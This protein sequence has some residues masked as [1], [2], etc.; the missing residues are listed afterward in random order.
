MDASRTNLYSWSSSSI[1]HISFQSFN[2]L[3]SLFFVQIRVRAN[4][5]SRSKWNRRLIWKQWWISQIWTDLS[6]KAVSGTEMKADWWATHLRS[7]SL[8]A[9]RHIIGIDSSGGVTNDYWSHKRQH[10]NSNSNN[11]TAGLDCHEP[12]EI[13]CLLP[14][15]LKLEVACSQ[16]NLLFAP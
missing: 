14:T 9:G 11:N 7:C 6:W 8:P 2:T 13:Q 5:C 16:Y 1:Q 4:E 12:S 15:Y 3:F 10:R